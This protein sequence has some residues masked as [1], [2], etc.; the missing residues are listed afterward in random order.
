MRTLNDRVKRLLRPDGNGGGDRDRR[1]RVGGW[2]S[3]Y[4]KRAVGEHPI[5]CQRCLFLFLTRGSGRD[6]MR[7]G[8]GTEPTQHRTLLTVTET[9][10]SG[11]GNT[12]AA[13]TAAAAARHTPRERT[14]P[15]GWVW[16]HGNFRGPTDRRTSTTHKPTQQP[17]ASVIAS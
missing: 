2:V 14:T 5:Y 4:E 3:L 1:Q 16:Y 12:A 7:N 11:R 13:A 6:R 9:S 10:I 15:K 8:P 17:K